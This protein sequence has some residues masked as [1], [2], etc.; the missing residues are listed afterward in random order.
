MKN[1]A[2]VVIGRN[3][4][5][6]LEAS[7]R[8][9]LEARL[10]LVYVDSDSVDGSPTI[11]RDLDVPI[12]C[13]DAPPPLSAARARNA[14]LRYLTETLDDVEFV[15]FLD[16]DCTLSRHFVRA[17]VD[18]AGQ[19]DDI[20]VVVGHLREA[21]PGTSLYG[22]LADLEWAGSD[23][24]IK[25]FGQLGGIMLVRAAAFHTVGGF[26][27]LMVAGEDPEF[28]VRLALAGYKTVR[29]SAEMALH[30]HGVESFTAWWRR[31]RR[32]G[33]A[34]THRYVKNGR[35]RVRDCRR[36]F[37]STLAWGLALPTVVAVLA[38]PTHGWSLTAIGAYLLLGSRILCHYRSRGVPGPLA[39]QATM[40]GLIA[41]FANAQG[42]LTYVGQR[43]RG[44]VQLIEY[45][46]LNRPV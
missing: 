12:V 46:K 32:A 43:L 22:R 37:F 17:A 13:L 28:C 45:K 23:G 42:V 20:A 7:L 10:P 2:A 25:D 33:L 9:V 26:D 11:A 36:E 27:P 4:A 5:A 34:L 31:A 19:S 21:R 39:L 29:I 44:R 14:G 1:V 15:L 6:R 38:I 16:G 18:Q 30:E 40:F 35:S 3:E 24:E 8:S 41:K